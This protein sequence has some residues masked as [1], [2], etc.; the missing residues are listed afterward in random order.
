MVAMDFWLQYDLQRPNLPNLLIPD[1]YTL[2]LIL[3]VIQ[4]NCQS[5]KLIHFLACLSASEIDFDMLRGNHFGLALLHN[6]D[7][8]Y[9]CTICVGFRFTT[10]IGIKLLGMKSK[11][12]A[13]L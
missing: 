10:K 3:V 8:V 1:L 4:A 13:Y 12:F 9:N 6:Q 2:L 7:L 5:Y 11:I